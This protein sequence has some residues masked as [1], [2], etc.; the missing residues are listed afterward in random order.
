LMYLWVKANADFKKKVIDLPA[1]DSLRIIASSFVKPSDMEEHYDFAAADE[2]TFKKLSNNYRIILPL[3]TE[4]PAL[5][6]NLYNRNA[7]TTKALEELSAIKEQIITLNLS[8]MPVKDA[9]LK[10]IAQFIN[11][12]HLNLNFTDITGEGLKQLAPLK[13]LQS[14]SLAG[15]K[16]SYNNLQQL[17]AIP[18]LKQV[19]VWNTGLKDTEIAQ[20]G[21]AHKGIQFITGFKD[22][23]K[24][25]KLNPPQL[26]YNSFV[27]RNSLSADSLSLRHPIRDVNIYY[28]IDGSDPDSLSPLFK[29]G[30]AFTKNA[31]IKFKAYKTGWI[32]SDIVTADLFKSAYK[33]D[34]IAVLSTIATAYHNKITTLING[35]LGGTDVNSDRWLGLQGNMDIELFFNKPVVLSSVTFHSMAVPLFGK[36]PP[37]VIEIW[38]GVN[39]SQMQLLGTVK[40]QITPGENRVSFLMAIDCKLK[41]KN[42]SYLKAKTKATGIFLLDEIFF[43]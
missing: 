27:I 23:G 19:A 37:E 24:P 13:Y 38:G 28:T 10:T 25:I 20:L 40:P 14:I 8:K 29:K 3:A 4:S 33:A 17:A 5:K 42:I 6:V 31:T 26:K 2:K 7:Y 30:I 22:D 32:S 12:R 1:N 43:N 16:V 35:Q 34:S 39:K 15:S 9:E 36:R 41:S 21:K 18:S 11:L